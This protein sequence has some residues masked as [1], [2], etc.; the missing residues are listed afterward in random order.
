MTLKDFAA[1]Q[2]RLSGRYKQGAVE[3]LQGEPQTSNAY[4]RSRSDTGAAGSKSD[5]FPPAAAPRE[6][7]DPGEA[8]RQY[9]SSEGTS[10][11]PKEASAAPV[12]GSFHSETGDASQ[13]Q[14]PATADLDN[15]L[16]REAGACPDEGMQREESSARRA[17]SLEAYMA[18][19]R[20]HSAWSTQQPDSSAGAWAAGGRPIQPGRQGSFTG[21]QHAEDQS[22]HLLGHYFKACV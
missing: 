14:R 8:W 3:S 21:A 1:A 6:A 19:E 5:R 20:S 9:I 4:S 7:T 16:S 18:R 13:R 17:E 10:M 15:Y 12:T 2:D 22:Q 11:R